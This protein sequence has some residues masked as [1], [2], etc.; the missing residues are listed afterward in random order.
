M[1]WIFD[2]KRRARRLEADR[3]YTRVAQAALNPVLFQDFG[4][5]DTLDGRFDITSLFMIL[6]MRDMDK[7]SSQ[8]LFDRFFVGVDRSLREMGIGDLSVPRH[9]KRMMSA[10]NGRR[11]AYESALASG[12]ALM[13]A[14]AI[15]RNVYGTVP[16]ISPET[17]RMLADYVQ[18]QAVGA[19]SDIVR[20]AA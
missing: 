11:E 14:E 7:K 3:V 5:P 17:V 2:P 15:R 4:V 19:V 6:A 16:G 1:F 9:M 13:L 18:G 12:N 10:F 20:K 8:A